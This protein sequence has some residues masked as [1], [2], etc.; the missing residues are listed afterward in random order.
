[1][2]AKVITENAR[3]KI[4]D[5]LI[6]HKTVVEQDNDLFDMLNNIKT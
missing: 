3:T 1:M 5:R 6:F 2:K 4:R